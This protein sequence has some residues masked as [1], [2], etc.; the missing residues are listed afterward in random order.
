[1]DDF[2]KINLDYHGGKLGNL[3]NC[4]LDI[5]Y[6]QDLLDYKSEWYKEL[7]DLYGEENDLNRKLGQSPAAQR[8]GQF[9][10]R[11]TFKQL[12]LDYCQ[13]YIN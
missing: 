4:F 5:E 9:S 3:G 8:Y 13:K 1:M 2:L 10:T 11:D 7:S 6:G 12:V